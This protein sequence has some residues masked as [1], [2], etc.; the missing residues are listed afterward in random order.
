MA[1]AESG[2]DGARIA[3]LHAR[4]EAIDGYT[5]RSRAGRLL[6]GLGF[7]SDQESPPVRSFSGGWRMRLNLG[8]A[9]M[10][11][12]DLLLLAEPTNH[13]D[14]AAVLWLE[15][16][17]R[18]YPGTLLLISHDRDFLDTVADHIL[19][20]ERQ[21]LK[22]YSGNYSAIERRRAEQLAGQQA[23]F[24][25]QPR[26]IAHIRSYV[27]RFRAQATKARQAQSRLKALERME[28]TAPAH[29]D[30][31][32]HFEFLAPPQPPTPLLQR[33]RISAGYGDRT[34]ISCVN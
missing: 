34:I 4:N 7:T 5:A 21:Q 11:R 20:I 29:V 30:S 27:A 13:L 23:A 2:H 32:D 25:N 28:L 3:S 6:H 24:E 8:R 33:D 14:L 15:D 22:L 10:C 12:S 17:L 1:E 18:A 9:L 16:W 19:H 31:P 26:E